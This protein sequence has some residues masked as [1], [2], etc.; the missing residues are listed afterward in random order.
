MALDLPRMV[1]RLGTRRRAIVFPAIETTA[2]ELAALT[3][4]YMKPVRAW[5]NECSANI[6]PVYTASLREAAWLESAL[7]DEARRAPFVKDSL[8]DIAAQ[9]GASDETISRL[10][11]S[12]TPELS[13]WIVRAERIHRSR[14]IAAAKTAAG[15]RLETL[16]GP[17]TAQ[18]TLRAA[19]ETNL[20]LIRDISDD[21]RTRI[22]RIVFD[23]FQ[24]RRP[25]REV[26]KALNDALQIGRKRALLIAS[27]Q[28][29]KLSAL[30]D[31]ERQEELGIDKFRWRHSGKVHYRPHHKA[32]DG[33]VF[34]WRGNSLNG[35]LP[36]IAINC[37]CKA[38][39]YVDLDN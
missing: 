25:R 33:K 15:V 6:L 18:T 1:K 28:T 37:G 30:L 34:P 20:G 39:A 12:L 22:G 9:M 4:L 14:F 13:D 24:Q 7:R 23:G 31:Q 32:R 36:G 2:G 3:R 26:A 16:I 8:D 35:D 19:Y 29:T 21:M 27:D 38:Q 17:E 10:I 11:V 5:S